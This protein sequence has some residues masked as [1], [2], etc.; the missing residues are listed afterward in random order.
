MKYNAEVGTKGN[1]IE[2]MKLV[3]ALEARLEKLEKPA[4][5]APKLKLKTPTVKSEDK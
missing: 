1:I 5:V 3:E 2:L 4:E